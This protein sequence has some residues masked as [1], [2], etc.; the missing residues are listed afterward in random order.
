MI[1][2]EALKTFD[3]LYNETYSNV[4]RYVVINCSNAEDIRDIVQNVYLELLHVLNKRKKINDYV[5]YIIG[6][7]K[8]KV[9]EYYRFKYKV[10]FI[11]LFSKKEDINLLENVP[12]K[13]DLEDIVIRNEDMSFIWEFLKN[14]KIIIFKIFYLYYFNDLSIKTIAKELDIT[15]SNVKHYLYRTLNELKLVMKD[16]GEENV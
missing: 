7:T 12:D 1:D 13:I 5:S 3:E 6:I 14:K 2:Q 16:R 9:N 15:E 10:K 4:L 11:D 8:N